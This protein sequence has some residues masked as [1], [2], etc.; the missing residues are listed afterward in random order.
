MALTIRSREEVDDLTIVAPGLRAHGHP[1]IELLKPVRFPE[2]YNEDFWPG[3]D[4][5]FM[6]YSVPPEVRRFYQ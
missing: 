6:H 2:C 5:E 4:A 1:P 3:Q